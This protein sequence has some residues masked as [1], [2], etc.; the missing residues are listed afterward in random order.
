MRAKE[1]VLLDVGALTRVFK[2][3]K[4]VV[5]NMLKQLEEYFRKY[6]E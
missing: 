1:P 5:I 4:K 3:F 6:G 2:V